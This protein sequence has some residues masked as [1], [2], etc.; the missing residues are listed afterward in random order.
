MEYVTP[1]SQQIDIQT[2]YSKAFLSLGELIVADHPT[3]IWT[4]LGSCVSVVLYNPRKKVSALCHAQ[5]AESKVLGYN[6]Y[7]LENDKHIAKVVKNDF[8][9]VEC[10]INF[11]LEKLF[12]MGIDKREIQASVYGGANVIAEFTHKIGSE[13]SA[14][15]IAALNKNDIKI[16]K[17]D[18]GGTK[19]RTIRHFS[20]TG[21]TN[22]RVL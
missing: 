14:A 10:S 17:K 20:D 13:N 18:V 12:S 8:R 16:V 5:L 22:V 19:S 15:A 2:I 4:V 6:A 7:T 9:F 1:L 11:M 3:H 21:E